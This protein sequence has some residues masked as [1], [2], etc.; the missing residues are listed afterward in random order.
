MVDII[1]CEIQ[2]IRI[3]YVVRG[4]TRRK[5]AHAG[6]PL[7]FLSTFLRPPPNRQRSVSFPFSFALRRDRQPPPSHPHGPIP[8]RPPPFALRPSPNAALTSI[9][10]NPGHRCPR[11]GRRSDPIAPRRH[12]DRGQEIEQR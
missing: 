1:F 3:N 5:I 8:R 4:V 6:S 11:S 12:P 10:L 7:G 2:R 9:P